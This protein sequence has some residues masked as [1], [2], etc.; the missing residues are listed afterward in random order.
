MIPGMSNATKSF[1]IPMRAGTAR[2][3]SVGVVVAL[4][5]GY[6]GAAAVSEPAPALDIGL[7]VL[8]LAGLVGAILLFL[9]SYGQM[10]QRA[11]RELDEREVAVRNRAYVLTHQMMVIALFI[12]FFWVESAAKLGLW[13]PAPDELGNLITAFALSS[14]ALPAAILAWRDRTIAAEELEE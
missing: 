2:A 10:S 14:M 13:L 6:L 8:K 3:L 12:A 9:S 7:A 5:A 11:E 4:V 1:Q